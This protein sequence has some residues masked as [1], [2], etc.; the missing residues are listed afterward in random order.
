M[1]LILAGFDPRRVDYKIVY[2]SIVPQ[3]AEMSARILLNKAQAANYWAGM[4]IPSELIAK[5][6]LKFDPEDIQAW[7]QAIKTQIQQTPT[8]PTNQAKP[9]DPS[10]KPPQGGK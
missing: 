9:A 10:K 5:H 3:S 7:Q 8:S 2:P 6:L 4:G 1:S